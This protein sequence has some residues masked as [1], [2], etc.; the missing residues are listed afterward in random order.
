[1]FAVISTPT[2]DERNQKYDTIR[3]L[4][5]GRG[6][7]RHLFCPLALRMFLLQRLFRHPTSL[8]FERPGCSLSP[9]HFFVLTAVF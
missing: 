4:P 8:T 7:G 1:M 9:V 3:L 2:Y 6:R 5:R